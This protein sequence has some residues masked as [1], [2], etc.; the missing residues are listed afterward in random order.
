MLYFDDLD[1]ADTERKVQEVKKKIQ[2]YKGRYEGSM[3][4]YRKDQALAKA[5]RYG[6][7]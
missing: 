6:L 7:L 1:K 5:D 2:L 4:V 3:G